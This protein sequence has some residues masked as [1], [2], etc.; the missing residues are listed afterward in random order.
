MAGI[1]YK[2]VLASYLPNSDRGKSV[3]QHAEAGVG[4]YLLNKERGK[5]D[6]IIVAFKYAADKTMPPHLTDAS[7]HQVERLE[8]RSGTRK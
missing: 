6:K 1:A 3:L 5:T 4:Y 7:P 2:W 8:A